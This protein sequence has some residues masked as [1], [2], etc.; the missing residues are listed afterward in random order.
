MEKS[1]G[2]RQTEQRILLSRYLIVW[3]VRYIAWVDYRAVVEAAA[4]EAAT[5]KSAA[6]GV[7][8]PDGRRPGRKRRLIRGCHQRNSAG[9]KEMRLQRTFGI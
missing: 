3:K 4:L 7:G 9:S 2:I 1:L 6:D 5:L 8:R